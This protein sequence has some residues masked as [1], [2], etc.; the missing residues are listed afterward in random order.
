MGRADMNTRMLRRCVAC[1]AVLAA[2]HV[3]PVKADS[4]G[5]DALIQEGL[6]LRR[7]G[8]PEQALERFRH[9]H[10]LAPSP[11][12]Y[13]QMGLVEAT[14]KRWTDAET[15]LSVALANTDDGWVHKNR[16]FLDQAL[17]L[18]REHLG[19]LVVT[20]PAGAEVFVAGQ[21]VGI[22][23]AV[24]ALRVVEGSVEVTATAAGSEPF[25]QSVTIHAGK[26]ASVNI[27]MSPVIVPSPKVAEPP[28]PQTPEKELPAP[29]PPPSPPP[30][31]EPESHWH[32]WTGLGLAALGAASV[33]VGIYW[34]AIDGSCRVQHL[35]PMTGEQASCEQ[36]VT[37]TGGEI[38]VGV[39]AAA[40]AAGAIVFFTGPS[41]TE[42]A[43]ALGASPRGLWLR[44]R[45]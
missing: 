4:S 44:G 35:N 31:P 29:P 36:Y 3:S 42:P 10:E 2:L 26:R 25:K 39:G 45:F 1:L 7:E 12:T 23:P 32:T 8:K 5:A 13:G 34:I 14:L 20:G 18:C 30:A 37:K 24:P 6:N 11:R 9:A 21:S 41:K 27:A 15:H 28:P 40:I 16:A 43:V 33:G 22:L 19:D 38:F 17:A